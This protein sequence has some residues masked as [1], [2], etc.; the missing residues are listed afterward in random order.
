M[1]E[2]DVLV[3]GLGVTGMSVARHLAS[4]GIPFAVADNRKQP[5]N[6]ARFARDYPDVPLY[7][8]EFDDRLF[9]S[10]SEIVL[11]PGVSPKT[12]AVS[13][14]ISEGVPV[15]GDIEIFMRQRAPGKAVL[16][17]TGSNGKSTVCCLLAEMA[18]CAGRR[19]AL[20]GNYGNPVLDL[21]RT[22]EPPDVYILELSSFQL[23]TT[24]SLR[25][26]VGAVLNISDDHLDRYASIEEY[27]EVKRRIFRESCFAVCNREELSY[28]PPGSTDIRS[29]SFGLDE[30]ANGHY[31]IRI[32]DG[33]HYVAYGN[34]LLMPTSEIPMPGRH[35]WLNALAAM[36]VGSSAGF[37]QPAMLQ[38]IRE[39]VGLPHRMQNIGLYAGMQWVNDSKATNVAATVA[40]LESVDHPCIWLAGGVHKGGC[41]SPLA[42]AA[43][44][45]RM[46]IFYGEAA[47][48]LA[49]AVGGAVPVTVTATLDEAVAHAAR[50]RRKGETVLLSPACTS[51]D[52]YE[53]YAGRGEHFMDLV[54]NLT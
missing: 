7:L 6:H 15:F 30:P 10:A 47:G 22:E 29:V 2:G 50:E 46:A 32:K 12:P 42:E 25:Q 24:Y 27:A 45:T 44:H 53:N 36:A 39:F 40:A 3:V 28:P 20:G 13:S 18:K 34:R 54:R 8:G 48:Q 5:P 16:A 37:P 26:H 17:V 11:S 9:R 33:K 41:L 49:D 51:F 4:Y 21:I 31:G 1:R 43:R 23:E 38:A 52:Q 19:Y 35:G 14:A